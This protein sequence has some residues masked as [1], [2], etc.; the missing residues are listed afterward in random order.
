MNQ[1]SKVYV[2]GGTTLIGTAICTLLQRARYQEVHGGASEPDLTDARDV[3]AYFAATKPEYVFLTAGLSGGI[4]ENLRSPADLIR[5]NLLVEC[6][7]IE[8]A[9]RHQV[10]K[11]VYLASSCSYPRMSPQPIHED[12]LLTGPLEPTNEAYAVAKIAGIKLCQAYRQQF[13]VNFVVAIP[14][15]AFGP[16]DDFGLEKSHVIAALIRKMHEAKAQHNR[17]VAIWGSGTPRREFIFSRDLADACVFVMANYNGADP[18]NIGNGF[19]LSI[20]ALAEAIR[21]TVGYTGGL[22]FDT[23]KPDGMPRKALDSSKLRRL[24]WR[25]QTEFR[26]ALAETYRWF[27]GSECDKKELTHA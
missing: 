24:G 3:D 19:D 15:N 9:Y 11:L 14:A 4:A 25:P 12:A 2:A 17:E 6:N 26:D 16:A 5:N 10:R 18:I 1:T 20:R 7:V 22:R 27:L 8:S 21:D 23:S 13:G